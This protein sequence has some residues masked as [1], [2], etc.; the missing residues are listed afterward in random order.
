MLRA[1]STGKRPALGAPAKPGQ[2]DGPPTKGSLPSPARAAQELRQQEIVS[3]G[4]PAR[5]ESRMSQQGPAESCAHGRINSG[6]A[7]PIV[8]GRK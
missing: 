6:Q 7:D 1:G 2:T 8:G 4:Q 3:A 5:I